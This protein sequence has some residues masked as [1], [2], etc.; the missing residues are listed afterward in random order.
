MEDLYEK[1]LGIA[2]KAHEGQF[3]KFSQE[4]VPYITHPVAVAAQFTDTRMKCI[5]VLH[6][7]IEDT[8]L[9]TTDLLK[10][11]VPAEIVGVVNTLS[12]R[13]G[14]KYF[15]YINRVLMWPDAMQIKIADILHNIQTTPKDMAESRYLPTL[16]K[17]YA[18]M[19]RR[20]KLEL[21]PS[22][23]EQI[24]SLAMNLNSWFVPAKM[25]R[26]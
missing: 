5:A 12:R 14:E 7:V 10:M 4:G 22:M 18:E 8:P 16:F 6:D 19:I 15:D 24:V 3:R 21:E 2:T 9:D 20:N 17:I 11:G 23:K 13:D 1:C 25:G 26:E